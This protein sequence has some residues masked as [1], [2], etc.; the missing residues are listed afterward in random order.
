MT[1]PVRSI[2]EFSAHVVPHCTNYT[3]RMLTRVSVAY[4]SSASIPMVNGYNYPS[5]EQS[6]QVSVNRVRSPSKRSIENVDC[7]GR[8]V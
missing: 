7:Q 3:L 2:Y 4:K 1:L 8:D 6:Q 5:H